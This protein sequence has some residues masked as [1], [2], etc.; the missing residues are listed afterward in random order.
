LVAYTD[1]VTESENSEGNAFGHKRL[2]SMLGDYRSQDPQKI[3]QHILDELS[4]HSA[5]CSQADDITIVV[6][7]VEAQE[8]DKHR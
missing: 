2:E 6:M 1:G 5:G 8:R 3:L 4:A 7:Q